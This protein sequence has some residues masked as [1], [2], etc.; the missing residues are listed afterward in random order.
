MGFLQLQ[1]VGFLLRRLLSVRSTGSTA[2]GL[3][4]LRYIELAALR[5]VRS[6]QARDRTCVPCLG[7]QILNHWITREVLSVLRY[8]SIF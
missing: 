8:L 1:H 5:H 2:H 4:W 7:G 3:Q 6:S